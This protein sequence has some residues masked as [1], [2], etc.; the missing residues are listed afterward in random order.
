MVLII[1]GRGFCS[2]LINLLKN[3]MS[4]YKHKLNEDIKIPE[5]IITEPLTGR[6]KV[7]IGRFGFI[8]S[9]GT[10]YYFQMSDVID[11]I[12]EGDRVSFEIKTNSVR[13]KAGNIKK[14]N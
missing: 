14:L 13:P 10:D 4:Y 8:Q 5:V 3:N 11:K 2:A 7:I 6:I 12:N 9:K 1:Q